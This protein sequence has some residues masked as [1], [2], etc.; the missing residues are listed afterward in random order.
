MLGGLV[1]AYLVARSCR[2]SPAARR[3]SSTTPGP[4]SSPARWSAGSGVLDDIFDLDALT[5][6]GGQV[7]AAG[8]ARLLRHP[9]R[10]FYR[11]RRRPVRPRPRPGRAAHRDHRGRHRQRGELRRRPRRPRRRRRRHRRAGLLPLLLPAGQ[12][13]R[14]D[15]GDD[16]GP[17]LARPWPGPARASWP[18]NFHPARLFMGDSGSMLIGLVLSATRDHAHRPVR[19]R[20]TSTQGA[21]GARASLLPMLLP[22][23]CRS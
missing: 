16:R 11:A 19:G 3:S 20:A 15:P 1:A 21:D 22:W 18:H 12:P 10:Y 4:C 17:A 7:L 14:R 8:P 23:R 5:K 2:S 9:V 6:F 13:Q